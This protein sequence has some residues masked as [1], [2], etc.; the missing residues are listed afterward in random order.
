MDESRDT[1]AKMRTEKLF[2]SLKNSIFSKVLGNIPA[3]VHGIKLQLV[4]RFAITCA[5]LRVLF[6]LTTNSKQGPVHMRPG[7]EIARTSLKSSRWLV[8]TDSAQ[9]GIKSARKECNLKYISDFFSVL[10]QHTH[11][12]R[13]PLSIF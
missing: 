9:T 6:Y 2:L 3:S 12:L 11:K 13:E 7:T 5:F 1:R 8:R 4:Y 10:E